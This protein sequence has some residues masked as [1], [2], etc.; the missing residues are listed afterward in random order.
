MK[1]FFVFPSRGSRVR[2]PF[3]ALSRNQL[4]ITKLNN[5]RETKCLTKNTQKTLKKHY[6]AIFLSK[7]RTQ[8]ARKC[9]KKEILHAFCKKQTTS[10]LTLFN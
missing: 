2:V 9:S 4:K 5:S 6:F 1:S 10:L 8:I 7:N 3:A